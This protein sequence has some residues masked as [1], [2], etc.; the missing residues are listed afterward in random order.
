LPYQTHGEDG[1][2]DDEDEDVDY[3]SNDR[4]SVAGGQHSAAA[5]MRNTRYWESVDTHHQVAPHVITS[6]AARQPTVTGFGTKLLLLTMV[7]TVTSTTTTTSWLLE[8]RLTP[9]H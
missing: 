1:D 5:T 3:G 8:R 6:A 9:F 2:D 7:V 4:E